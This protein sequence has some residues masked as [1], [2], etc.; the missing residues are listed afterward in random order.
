MAGRSE[1][2]CRTQVLRE[3]PVCGHRFEKHSNKEIR[4]LLYGHYRIAY[5]IDEQA[6]LHPSEL[7]GFLSHRKRFATPSLLTVTERGTS[8]GS[9]HVSGQTFRRS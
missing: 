3:F 1:N 4:I 5:L 9:L 8:E 7:E 6:V 2:L